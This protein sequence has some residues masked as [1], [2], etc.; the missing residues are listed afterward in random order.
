M[1]KQPIIL[2]SKP[3]TLENNVS[4]LG[5]DRVGV[6]CHVLVI[7]VVVVSEPAPSDMPL[8]LLLLNA[9]QC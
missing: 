1:N 6:C 9:E 4:I 7:C 5:I 2:F 3:I 8:L